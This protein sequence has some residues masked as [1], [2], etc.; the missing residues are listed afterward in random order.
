MYHVINYHIEHHKFLENPGQE[1]FDLSMQ[2]R[3]QDRQASRPMF[4]GGLLLQDWRPTLQHDTD[5]KMAQLYNFFR[6]E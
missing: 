2:T 5:A 4:V 6:R 3:R 1:A